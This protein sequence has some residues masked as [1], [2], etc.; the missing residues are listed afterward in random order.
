M[1]FVLLKF[2]FDIRK[3]NIFFKK[4]TCLWFSLMQDKYTGIKRLKIL[5]LFLKEKKN[6]TIFQCFEDLVSLA[7]ESTRLINA[8][9]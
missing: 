4:R 6:L 3:K 2:R 5:N 7:E 9:T 8:S 1:Q